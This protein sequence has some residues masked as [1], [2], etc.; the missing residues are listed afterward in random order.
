MGDRV[1]QDRPDRHV[2]QPDSAARHGGDVVRDDVVEDVEPIPEVLRQV[3]DVDAVDARRG[4]PTAVAASGKVALESVGVDRHVS[5]PVCETGGVTGLDRRADEDTA[6]VAADL[7]A[8][9]HLVEED[10]V[11]L[12]DSVVGQPEVE[13]AGAVVAAQVAGD[14][15]V[16]QHVVVRSLVDRD[17][18]SAAHA[19]VL[20]DPI[21]V[22]PDAEVRLLGGNVTDRDA[23]AQV[24]LVG[25][26]D[27]V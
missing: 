8:P 11:A 16:A 21:V 24:A 9:V 15:V 18:A 3:V 19:A 23:A 7:V 20:D 26:D 14:E 12:D 17:T 5:G 22:D 6:A 27:V 25:A 13:H 10:L 4:D 2:L 1:V